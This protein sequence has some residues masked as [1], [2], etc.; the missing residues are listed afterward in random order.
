MIAG[1][2]THVSSVLMKP[3]RPTDRK[4]LSLAQ[5][6]HIPCRR[7][8]PRH[9]ATVD[10]AIIPTRGTG[11]RGRET[12]D[13]DT[14]AAYN[15]GDRHTNHFQEF[16]QS[17]PLNSNQFRNGSEKTGLLSFSLPLSHRDEG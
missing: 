12:R 8:N 15:V 17:I 3:H 14:G 9:T 2:H 11:C 4:S 10:D 1:S 13:C 7:T 6:R 16:P 5:A